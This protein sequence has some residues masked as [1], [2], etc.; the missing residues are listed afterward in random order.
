MKKIGCRSIHIVPLAALLVW[1][2]ASQPKVEKHFVGDS[3]ELAE[4]VA[5]LPFVWSEEAE[6]EDRDQLPELPSLVQ[7]V[8]QNSF[9]SLPYEDM[10]DVKRSLSEAGLLEGETW[11]TTEY[12]ELAQRIGAGTLVR[13]EVTKGALGTGGLVSKTQ[14]AFKVA[15]VDGRTGGLLWQGTTESSRRGG[16]LFTAGQA[17]ELVSELSSDDSKAQQVLR[18]VTEDAVRKLVLSIPPPSHMEVHKPS[19]FGCSVDT[20]APDGDSPKRIEV[21]IQGTP[22]CH[23]SFD[24]GSFRR[25]VP[26]WEVEAG[27][28]EGNYSPQPGD[29]V[30]DAPITVRLESR[31]GV[32]TQKT[33]EGTE[34]TLP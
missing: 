21:S 24:I 14:V 30:T 23:A 19:I 3:L 1:G 7:D 12:G 25:F 27:R 33:V 34:V 29:E 4:P 28:Y 6:K 16:V 15:F 26:L 32:M 5:V 22:N 18:T 11:R 31:L 8:F 13:G 10:P 9:A 17:V 20:V 2:C